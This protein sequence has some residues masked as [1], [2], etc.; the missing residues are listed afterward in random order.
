MASA[1]SL[2]VILVMTFLTAGS[3][4][5]ADHSLDDVGRKILH[6]YRPTARFERA[7]AIDKTGVVPAGRVGRAPEPVD[8]RSLKERFG[9]VEI[10]HLR[11]WW[12]GFSGT[13]HLTDVAF[14]TRRREGVAEGRTEV[15][16]DTGL[17][18]LVPAVCRTAREWV[19]VE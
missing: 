18:P 19:P 15:L 14:L 10:M 17:V 3:A 2:L 9:E 5:A 16:V 13:A 1:F 11:I 7:V 6:C 8:V 4:M 12:R